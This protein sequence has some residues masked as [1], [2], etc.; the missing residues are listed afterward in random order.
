M[1]ALSCIYIYITT[2][3]TTTVLYIL[4]VYIECILLYIVYM[5]T[6]GFINNKKYTVY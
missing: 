4:I 2:T 5:Y 3:T 6:K 1:V